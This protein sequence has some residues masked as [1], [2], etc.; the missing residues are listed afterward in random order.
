MINKNKQQ[1]IGNSFGKLIVLK[2]TVE[3]HKSDLQNS[4]Q[5]PD[6][7]SLF[8][9][10]KMRKYARQPG[11]CHC[12]TRTYLQITDTKENYAEIRLKKS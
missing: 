3:R 6:I 12:Q 2:R 7:K 1:I 9:I 4:H 11:R 8:T 10:D 5:K